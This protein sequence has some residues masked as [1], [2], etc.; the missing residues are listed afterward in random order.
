[1]FSDLTATMLAAAKNICLITDPES[2]S[3]KRKGSG[4]R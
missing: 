2:A 1:M 3:A 4:G